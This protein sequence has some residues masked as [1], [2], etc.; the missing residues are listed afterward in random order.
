MKISYNWLCARL[1]ANM[2]KPEPAHLSQ[3]LTSIGLE[4]ES[5]EKYESVKGSLQGLIVGMVMECKQHPNA[6]KLKITQVDLGQS[7]W[8]QIV[9]G[10]SNVAEG[11]KVV[12]AI[13]GTQIFPVHG[14]AITLKLAKIRGAESHG[15][16]CAADEIGLSEDHEGILVLADEAKVGSPAANYFP[17][18]EDQIFEIG[19]TPNHMDAMSHYGVARDVC[20]FVSNRDNQQ[21]HAVFPD[22]S[23]FAVD[24]PAAGVSIHIENTKD[25]QRY[26]GITIRGI[27][28]QAS[29]QWMQDQLKAISIRP[30]N[31]IVDI[32]N[33]V[34]NDIGQPLHAY[35]GDLIKGNTIRVTNLPEG[36]PFL[37]LDDKERKLHGQDLMICDAENPICIAGVFGGAKSGVMPDTRNIFLESAWFNPEAIRKTSFSH[38]LRTDAANHFEKGMDISQTVDALKSA[39]ILIKRWAGG[40]ID[41]EI[42]DIYPEPKE[43]KQVSLT[44]SFLRKLSGKDYQPATVKKILTSLGFIIDKENREGLVASAPYYKPDICLPADLVEEIMRIDGFDAIEIPRAI[45][46]TPSVERGQKQRAY[47]EKVSAWLI[48][49]GFQ[50]ILTNSI[51]NSAY[52]SDAELEHS[53]RMINNLSAELNILRPSLLETGLETMAYN[54]NRKNNNLRLFEFGKTYHSSGPG[55]YTERNRLGIYITGKLSENSWKSKSSSSD[56]YY[57]KGLC[58]RILELLD[59]SEI[60]FKMIPGLNQEMGISATQHGKVLFTAGLVQERV[61]TQFEIRQPI[62]YADLDWDTLMERT[63]PLALQF[64]ELPR[65]MPVSRDIAMVVNKA[66]PYENVEKV[67]NGL[68]LDKLKDV[69]LFDIFES[70]KLGADK[71]SLAV[72]FRFLDGEKTLTDKEVEGMMNRIMSSLEKELNAEIRK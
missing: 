51:T 64:Q 55:H 59:I 70:E 67:L 68:G 6:D 44:Y 23:L 7:E 32:T 10:A 36:T 2:A 12:V 14:E 1:P 43:K 15:M 46:I 42:V 57:I 54:I 35:D 31:N 37:A 4:V 38:G 41:S 30:I 16:I 45:T 27:R 40:K 13:P 25:C 3:I 19:L 11:Q 53:V 48:G 29:P 33:Y 61:L 26:S 28:V 50:E 65:Q 60:H 58:G 63:N 17:L 47:K 18:Y 72:S 66:L 20:A 52:F 34:L 24:H 71:K 22:L 9:C 21:Y 69:Q 5:L 56:F 8:F 49:Q 39:A 62:F